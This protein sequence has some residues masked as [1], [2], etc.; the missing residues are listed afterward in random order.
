MLWRPYSFI[1][2]I[3]AGLI[4]SLIFI[5]SRYQT[6][7]QNYQTLKQQYRA[8][9]EAVKLQQ[10]KIDSLHQLDI[11]HTEKLNNAKAEIAKLNDAV[12][13]G[14]KQLHVNAVCPIPKTATT[15]SRHNEATPQLS[16]AAR[17]DY[18][19]LRAMIAENEKQTEYLQQY[20]KTQ[21]H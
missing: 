19:R 16:K 10:Q 6:I 9:I 4:L 13:A 5:N 18:F 1:G 20:I 17:E 2:V 3:I 15:Q 21:C 11:Q 12:R 8:Q 7:R 14:T